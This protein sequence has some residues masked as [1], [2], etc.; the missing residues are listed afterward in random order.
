MNRIYGIGVASLV[1]S[2]VASLVTSFPVQELPFQSHYFAVATC[3]G[4]PPPHPNYLGNLVVDCIFWFGIFFSFFSVISSKTLRNDKR[5]RLA[6]L[7]I[8]STL[9]ISVGSGALILL[10][11]LYGLQFIF[12][13]ANTIGLAMLGLSVIAAVTYV[14]FSVRAFR[15]DIPSAL[16]RLGRNFLVSLAGG[17]LFTVATSGFY[18]NAPFYEFWNYFQFL[19]KGPLA[20]WSCVAFLSVTVFALDYSRK[21]SNARQPGPIV[22]SI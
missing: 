2:I 14:A 19:M 5:Q 12:G 10:A 4:C 15:N 18:S 1:L 11:S 13:V 17:F 6:P 9:G 22:K 16:V 7:Q 3:V 8:L 20:L 21:L